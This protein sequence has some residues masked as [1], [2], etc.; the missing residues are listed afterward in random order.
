MVS[1]MDGLSASMRRWMLIGLI[2]AWCAPTIEAAD[3]PTVQMGLRIGGAVGSP[4]PIGEVP[5]GATGAPA[6]GIVAGAY[7]D[8]FHG[9]TWS[10]VSELRYVHYG[11]SF[12]TPL[13][14]QPYIDRVPVQTPD[15]GTVIF[16][17]NTTFTGTATGEFSND[18]LQ[19]PVY[20]AWQAFETWRF[21]GG[22]YAGW[23]VSTQ[24]HAT[25]VGQVGIRPE[26]V[27]KDMYFNDKINALDYGMELGAQYQAFSDLDID[28]RGILGFTSIFSKDF[29]TVD[30]TVQNVFFHVTLAYHI[31]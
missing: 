29:Q 16:E 22:L 27:E 7:V 20:A 6:V 8:W 19:V 4:I 23:L 26:T 31:L 11:S 18:Y 5:E 10:V 30:R 12:A 17:V 3:G 24:S 15:G 1:D 21:T 13:E 2:V 9:Q 25:G 14:D 28:L